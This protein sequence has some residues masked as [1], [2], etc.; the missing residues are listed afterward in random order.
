MKNEKGLENELDYKIP[1]PKVEG[2]NLGFISIWD[3][4]MKLQKWKNC[5]FLGVKVFKKTKGTLEHEPGFE[6]SLLLGLG[7]C[8]V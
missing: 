8:M 2:K 4:Y 6:I 7:L 5:A 3:Q 1:F